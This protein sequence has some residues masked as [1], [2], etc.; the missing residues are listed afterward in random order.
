M[1]QGYPFLKWFLGGVF[2]L[3]V[4]SCQQDADRDASRCVEKFCDAFFCFRFEEAFR[5]CLEEDAQWMLM[6]VSHLTEADADSI[7]HIR[8]SP[9]YMIEE[10]GEPA[11]DSTVQASVRI[12][13]A[14]VLDS[15]GRPPHLVTDAVMQVALQMKNGQWKVRRVDLLQ[16]GK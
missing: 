5:L 14:F 4:T 11:A 12:A 13:K 1:Q 16:N 15:L 9:E 7:R 2:S 8:V 10:W 6:Y 3:L